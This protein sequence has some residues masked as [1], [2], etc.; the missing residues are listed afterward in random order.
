MA[1][2]T[3]R[4]N[5]LQEAIESLYGNFSAIADPSI[6]TP[7]TPSGGHHGRLGYIISLDG[8]PSVSST[9]SHSNKN[10]QR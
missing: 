1:S 10:T 3:A 7:P 9:W 8:L 6:W 5:C 2:A 4:L